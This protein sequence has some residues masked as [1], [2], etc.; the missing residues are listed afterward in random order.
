LLLWNINV[1]LDTFTA[2]EF[3]EMFLGRQLCQYSISK[4]HLC[5]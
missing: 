2:A 1:N 3:D 5:N 4:V